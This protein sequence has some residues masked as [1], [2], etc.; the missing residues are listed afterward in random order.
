MAALGYPSQHDYHLPRIRGWDVSGAI[1]PTVAAD[2]RQ[3]VDL[4]GLEP[5][6]VP[7]TVYVEPGVGSTYHRYGTTTTFFVGAEDPYSASLTAAVMI[8]AFAAAA[9]TGWEGQ[10]TNGAALR[11]A[12]AITLH[13]ELAP[14]MQ[15]L[16]H[17][18][19]RHG[20]GDYLS[21]TSADARDPDATGCGLLFLAY[22]HDG[23][24]HTWPA[25]VQTGGRTLAGTYA[26]L[27]GVDA[28]HA[29]AAFMQALAPYVDGAGGLVVPAYGDPWCVGRPAALPR[30]HP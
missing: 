9:G 17:G 18:W 26:A 10:A 27:T 14:L 11:H 21:T 29:Y 16:L 2:Y 19:W 20:A 3:L 13:P 12:L 22:L 28:G 1:A 25:I 5:P 7:F 24:G 30:A 4:F 23:L 15:G 8:D 6:G